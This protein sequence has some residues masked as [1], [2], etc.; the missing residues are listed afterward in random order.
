TPTVFDDYTAENVSTNYVFTVTNNGNTAATYSLG[1]SCTGGETSCAVAPTVYVAAGSSSPVAVS[2]NT[3]AAGSTGYVSLV[4]T[5]LSNSSTGQVHVIPLSQAVSVSAGA[6]SAAMTQGN[7]QALGFTISAIGNTTSPITYTLGTV[8]TGVVTC[9]AT[10]TPSSVNITPGSPGSSNVLVTASSNPAGGAGA[11]TL[12]ASYTNAWG[13]LY[14]SGATTTITVPDVRNDSV[15]VTPKNDSIVSAPANTSTSYGFKVRNAGNSSATYNLSITSCTG[16]ASGT[17]GCSFGTGGNTIT[18]NA[19]STGTA[20]VYFS[21]GPVNQTITIGLHATATTAAGHVYSDDGLVEINPSIKGAPIIDLS[22]ANFGETITRDRCL[23][24]SLGKGAANNCGD[25]RLVHALPTIQTY[26]E[27]RTPA[28]IYDSQHAAPHPIISADVILPSDSLLPPTVSESLKVAG[29]TRATATWAGSAWSATGTAR[30]VAMSFDASSLAT[31]AYPYTVTVTSNFASGPLGTSASGNLIVVNRSASSGWWVAG[32]EQLFFPS[33][34]STRL[35]VGGDG[36]ARLY[37]WVSANVWKAASVDR[38]DSLTLS[39]STYTRWD[40][41]RLQVQFD[42]SGRHVATVTRQ[43]HTTSFG[44]SGTLLTSIAVP[45]ASS[46]YTFFHTGSAIDSVKSLDRKVTLTRGASSLTFTDPNGSTE[47]YDYA[48]STPVINK[49]TDQLGNVTTYQLDSISSTLSGVS[50]AMPSPSPAIVTTFRTAEGAA[51]SGPING[52]SVYTLVNGPRTDTTVT[53][54]WI[55]RFGEPTRM[56]NALGGSTLLERTDSRFPALVTQTT[57]PTGFVTTATYDSHGND[58]TITR[59]NPLG[60]GSNPTTS[61]G[62]DQ[63]FDFIS[64]VTQPTGEK[65]TM[66]YD[67]A[68]GNRTSQYPGTSSSRAV[69]FF[70]DSVTKNLSASQLPGTTAR[71]SIAYDSLGNVAV[72]KTPL[73]HETT[74]A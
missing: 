55:D 4:A 21:T 7:S 15:I 66:I 73:G 17:G 42:A 46:A 13:Q 25:L 72:T 26:T 8:C 41:H 47:R 1:S 56:V 54:V 64:S 36:S 52:D 43:G 60:D 16:T 33:D 22:K 24:I 70:Y 58:S 14:Q 67:P 57:D 20:S 51:L 74:Y 69:Q 53:R 62:W 37:H 23:T 5:G 50:V 63:T 10:P 59:R 40:E 31:G 65:M 29:V 68:T 27:P 32:V 30:R 49:Q 71:D 45:G 11:V 35:W 18:V 28:L 34:T 61:Y 48:G 12:T 3:S 6:A 9:P 2:F 19:G 38:P 44:Y 39:G